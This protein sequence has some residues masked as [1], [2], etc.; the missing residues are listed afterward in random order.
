VL[1]HVAVFDDGI[2]VDG[3]GRYRLRLTA[4]G[5][6]IARRCFAVTGTE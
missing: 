4:S 5:T 3:K 1:E 2:D 6:T